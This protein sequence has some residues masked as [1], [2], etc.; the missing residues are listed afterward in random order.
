MINVVILHK[1]RLS[2]NLIAA[3]LRQ[4]PDMHVTACADNLHEALDV[5]QQRPCDMVLVGA[6]L[7]DHGALDLVQALRSASSA[8]ILVMGVAD[9]EEVVL[10]Y[11][12]AGASGYVFEEDALASLL[13]NIRAVHSDEAL[14]TPELAATLMARLSEL[15]LQRSA[16]T[17]DFTATFDLTPREEEVLDLIGNGLSNQE[18]AERLVIEVGTVKNHVHSI[19]KKLD[20]NSRHAAARQWNGNSK[21]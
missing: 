2:C 20:V 6:S 12:E 18:I 19:L 10:R 5:L 13:R 8:K 21:P 3:A 7:S 11:V 17:P 9:A 1:S 14:V 4:E 15:A 16:V